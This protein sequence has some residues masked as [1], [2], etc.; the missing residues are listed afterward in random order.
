M[1]RNDKKNGFMYQFLSMC[2]FADNRKSI[3]VSKELFKTSTKRMYDEQLEIKSPNY[4]CLA[5]VNNFH[6]SVVCIEIS[7]CIGGGSWP[8][9]T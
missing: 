9:N 8:H 4:L 6:N 5:V 2:A 1:Q 7:S 3:F